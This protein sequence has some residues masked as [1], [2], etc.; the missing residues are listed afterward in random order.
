MVSNY[1]PNCF[2]SQPEA[3][4]VRMRFS[5]SRSFSVTVLT[6]SDLSLNLG[7]KFIPSVRERAQRGRTKDR[8]GSG[9]ACAICPFATLYPIIWSISGDYRRRQESSLHRKWHFFCLA[10]S[11]PVC[12]KWPIKFVQVRSGHE[13]SSGCE[14]IAFSSRHRTYTL[15]RSGAAS[16]LMYTDLRNKA[17]N[18]GE[19]EERR[20]F[21]LLESKLKPIEVHY[22]TLITLETI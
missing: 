7:P 4:G 1:S 5:L 2:F 21:S 13:S 12:T 20:L 11:Q 3:P 9:E 19:K 10:C 8:S 15:A 17:S 16:S 14:A 6:R 18:K 22:F